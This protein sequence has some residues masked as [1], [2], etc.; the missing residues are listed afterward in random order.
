MQVS[1]IQFQCRKIYSVLSSGSV[2]V[3][4]ASMHHGIVVQETITNW[5]SI[6]SRNGCCL[7]SVTMVQ[8]AAAKVTFA[9]TVDKGNNV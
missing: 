8:G 3:K 2:D 9:P 5:R 4:G 1:K 7:A 6:D